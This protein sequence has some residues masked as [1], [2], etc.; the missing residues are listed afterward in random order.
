MTGAIQGTTTDISTINQQIQDFKDGKAKISKEDLT[1]LV[2]SQIKQDQEISATLVDLVDSYEEIDKNHDGIDYSEFETYQNSSQGMLSALGISPGSI[3]RQIDM[4]SLGILGNS[5]TEDSAG[6]SSQSQQFSLL[7]S[8]LFN[9]SDTS[10]SSFENLLTGGFDN[11]STSTSTSSLNISQLMQ[12]YINSQTK[13]DANTNTT[14]SDI[15]SSLID[16]LG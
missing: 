15:L 14:N 4:L 13:T 12:N 16:E 6:T 10:S 11:S 5:S 3:S 9:D 1:G 2:C 7:N 8:G